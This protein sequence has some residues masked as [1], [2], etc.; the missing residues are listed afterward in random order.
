M[1]KGL[2]YLG[3]AYGKEFDEDECKVYYEFL[4]DYSKD[5]FS[6]AVKD[7]I[8]KSK[9]LPKLNELIE[10]CE[11]NQENEKTSKKIALLEF[12]REEGYFKCSKEYDKASKWFLE[13]NIPYWLKEDAKKYHEKM[14]QRALE[15][16][17]VLMIGGSQDGEVSNI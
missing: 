15:T 6:R 7:I 1:V 11:S 16:S 12:M 4:K 3:I 5:T 9:F 14:K 2:K 10:E 13:D 8:R 17:E